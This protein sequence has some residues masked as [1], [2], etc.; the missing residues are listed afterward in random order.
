MSRLLDQAIVGVLLLIAVV[1][2]FNALAPA[3]WRAK[4]LLRLGDWV[5][6]APLPGAPALAGLLTRAG[7]RRQAA[8][9]GCDGCGSSP[10]AKATNEEIRV[11]INKS[12][13]R[14]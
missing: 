8:F 9:G 14:S 4:S 13:R 3:L 6:R 5:L 2:A 12:G 7:Q 11:P 10:P 1:Y